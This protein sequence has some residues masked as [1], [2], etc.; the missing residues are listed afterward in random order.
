M[1]RRGFFGLLAA[2][3]LL[4]KPAV[5]QLKYKVYTFRFRIINEDVFGKT[6]TCEQQW[7]SDAFVTRLP[8]NFRRASN[9]V[10]STITLPKGRYRHTCRWTEQIT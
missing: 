7:E 10:K 6:R 5:G 8:V 9:R 1:N 2:I 3:A 4:P